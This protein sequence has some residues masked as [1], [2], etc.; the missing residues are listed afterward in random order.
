MGAS[1]A[2]DHFK[3]KRSFGFTSGATP[4]NTCNAH[5]FGGSSL[6]GKYSHDEHHSDLVWFSIVVK[7]QA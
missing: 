6:F 3:L 1:L 5:L 2:W 7:N 4:I